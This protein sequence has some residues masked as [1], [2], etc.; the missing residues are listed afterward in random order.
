M[1]LALLRQWKDQDLPDWTAWNQALAMIW[2]VG[3]S[4][5]QRGRMLDGLARIAAV[6]G[7]Y[8]VVS[9]G[10]LKHGDPGIKR[11]FARVLTRTDLSPTS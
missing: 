1:Q 4:M 5:T 2:L 7:G 6:R 8:P 11:F 10:R 3:A 9:A